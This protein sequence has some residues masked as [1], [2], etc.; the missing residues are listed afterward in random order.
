MRMSKRTRGPDPD[1]TAATLRV[2]LL[3][4]AELRP[5][6]DN[7]RLNDQAVDAVA[8]SIREF[9]FRQPLVV[10]DD[11]VIIVGH[12]RYKAA[13]RL[14]L[15]RVPCHVASDLTPAQRRAYRIADNRTNELAEW[16]YDLLAQELG[17]LASCNF[18]LETLAFPADQL[19]ALLDPGLR[20]GLTDPDQVPAAPDAATTQPGDLYL[21]GE[22]RLL[23][24][25]AGNA[26]NVD[27]LTDGQTMHLVYTDPP[28]NVGV[29]PRSGTAIAA[30]QTSYP[31]LSRKMHHQGFDVARGVIDPKKARKKMRAKDRPLQGD[32]VSDEAFDRM[33]HAWFGQVARVLEPGR[34][35]YI[36][37]GHPNLGNYPPV[38][39]AHGLYF[40]QGIVWCKQHPVLTRKD[41][42]G[43]FELAFYG[44]R[45]GAGHWFAFGRD[46]VPDVWEARALAAPGQIPAG[47]DA[48]AD[49][50]K[51][52]DIG[53]G[54]VLVAPSGARLYLTGD[55]PPGQQP[56]LALGADAP[57]VLVRTDRPTDI[58][59][60][61]KVAPQKMQ[62]LT[63]KPVE[64][65]IRA[66]QCSTRPGERVV[67]LFA[68]S[69][70]TMI[71]AEQTGRRAYL[72]EIDPLY[73]DVIVQRWAD[74]SGRG[75]ERIPA[76]TA[77]TPKAKRRRRSA[78]KPDR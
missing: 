63:E 65:A 54:L 69:G 46:N 19:T 12:T 58:W 15:A 7:P 70:S 42:M 8:R 33:L 24:G 47:T 31:D 72:M 35:F 29:E 17:A 44:W 52:R 22:H 21:L 73:C 9:G 71:A 67:D 4:L 61:K 77:P 48:P 6:A 3:P 39:K 26:A 38:L 20:D 56:S 57:G 43:N 53:T 13:Q 14:G 51:P 25:D 36:W 1:T 68:G 59:H 78:K 28:Y 75:P 40:S 5:Y 30:G 76:G 16:N 55:V 45:I 27:R 66:L 2:V 23:C 64:L 50:G 18:D 60:V 10:D 11:R 49:L 37:G 62:H 32:F 41:F 34:S 74:F